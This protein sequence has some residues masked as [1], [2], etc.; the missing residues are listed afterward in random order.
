MCWKYSQSTGKL[1]NP[2]G[3]VVGNGYSGHGVGLNNPAQEST[4][5]IGPIPQGEWGIG[6]FFDDPGGKGYL[7]CRLTPV[8]GT[9]THHRAGFMIH[10]D[11][12]QGDHSASEGCI[13]LPRVLREMVHSSGDHLLRVVA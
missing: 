12:S 4:P 1:T 8:D 6:H 9:E 13:I 2:A 10:G 7:V 5:C 3:S 11:N